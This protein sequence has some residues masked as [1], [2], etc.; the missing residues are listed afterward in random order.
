MLLVY[1]LITTFM[2]EIIMSK[3]SDAMQAITQGV[4]VIGVDDGEKKNLMTAA[5]IT[6]I[7][8]LPEILLAVGSSHYTAKMIEKCG[9][10][11][12]SVLSPS[13]VEIAD[14]CGKHSARLTDKPAKVPHTFTAQ[15]DPIVEGA[16]AYLD[17]KVNKVILTDDHV[18]FCAAVVDAKKPGDEV[19]IYDEGTYFG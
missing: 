11:A 3:F 14:Y 17:C 16:A 10:F 18:L 15:G 1:Y 4:Y 5:W 12:V 8:S 9:H 6:Q 2:E 19:L 7:S 13:Q